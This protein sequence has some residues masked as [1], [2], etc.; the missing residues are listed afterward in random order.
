MT[1]TITSHRIR[2]HS[3]PEQRRYFVQATEIRRF[4]YNWALAVRLT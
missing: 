3:T 4:V 1:T 2:L